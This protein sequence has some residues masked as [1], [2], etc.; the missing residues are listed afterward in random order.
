M[1]LLL[2]ACVNPGNMPGNI[3]TDNVERE[4]QYINALKFY[5]EKTKFKVVFVE[6]TLC[7]FS[8]KFSDYIQEGRLEYITFQGNDYNRNLGKS[9]GEGQIIKYAFETSKFLNEAERIMKITGRLQLAN[10]KQIAKIGGGK[11]VFSNLIITDSETT[12]LSYVFIATRKF[13][14]QYFVPDVES[15]NDSIN[16][17]FEKY[18][19]DKI[20]DWVKDGNSHSFFKYPLKVIGNG[21]T[22]GRAYYNA[23]RLDNLRTLIRYYR[24]RNFVKN[25]IK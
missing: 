21:G 2:T 3:L 18:L 25:N 7:D 20:K 11:T 6:N 9:Y 14:K 1:T 10:I 19:Y 24:R 15:M 17:Y 23:S 8:N 4:T 13:F 12:S 16:Y 5:L 22:D